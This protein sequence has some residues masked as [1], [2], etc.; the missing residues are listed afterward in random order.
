MLVAETFQTRERTL[1]L[2]S[3]PYSKPLGGKAFADTP[4]WLAHDPI[5]GFLAFCSAWAA[6]LMWRWPDDLI[7]ECGP[8]PLLVSM[9]LVAR[10]WAGFCGL[11]AA[12]KVIGLLMRLRRRW[13][14][15]AELLIVAGLFMSVL[16]WTIVSVL[17]E[18]RFPRSVTP[19]ALAGL[20]L[21]AA[22]Q[23]GHWRP[24]P[25]SLR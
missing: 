10:V 3:R 4:E 8:V 22:W 24:K 19:I 12:L 20:A 13:V 16:L 15:W 7:N 21:G 1:P 11:A 17:L 2:V 9:P 18:M 23:L 6:M 5:P 14:R 25:R